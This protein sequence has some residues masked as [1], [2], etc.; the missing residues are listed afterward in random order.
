MS[1]A[2]AN[3]GMLRA[4]TLTLEE[5]EYGFSYFLDLMKWVRGSTAREAM[6][7]VEAA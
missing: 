4:S 3:A 5:Q 7:E 6:A 1:D 2:T